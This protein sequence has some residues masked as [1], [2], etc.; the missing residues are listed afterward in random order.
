MEGVLVLQTGAADRRREAQACR[1][2]EMRVREQRSQLAGCLAGAC[3]LG[4]WWRGEA[5]VIEAVGSGTAQLRR[6][7]VGAAE[8]VRDAEGRPLG[9]MQ[10]LG[11]R[12]IK[13]FPGRAGKGAR[14]AWVRGRDRAAAEAANVVACFARRPG[15]K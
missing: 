11:E 4:S 13:V 8:Q 5:M 12:A 14:R 6:R 9:R 1:S 10:F 3:G 7:V 2:R 15:V